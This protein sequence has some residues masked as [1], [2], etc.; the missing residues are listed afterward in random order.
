[1]TGISEYEGNVEMFYHS[2]THDLE[3]FIHFII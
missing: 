3:L 2:V 1:M